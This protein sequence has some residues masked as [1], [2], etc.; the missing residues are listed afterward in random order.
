MCS[1]WRRPLFQFTLPK[2]WKGK[3]T[4]SRRGSPLESL[5]WRHRMRRYLVNRLAEITNDSIAQGARPL[6]VVGAAG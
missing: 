3:L 5:R 2:R 1:I 6:T 4:I